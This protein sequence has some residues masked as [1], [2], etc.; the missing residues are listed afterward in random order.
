MFFEG[1]DAVVA[2]GG[3]LGRQE[4]RGIL[5]GSLHWLWQGARLSKLCTGEA[6]REGR[7]GEEGY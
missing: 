2:V 1:V 3:V 5:P 4:H 7:I 6:R